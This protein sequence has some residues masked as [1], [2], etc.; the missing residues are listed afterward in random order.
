MISFS[1]VVHLMR[2]LE[3]VVIKST[4]YLRVFSTKE[5]TPSTAVN[6]RVPSL[7]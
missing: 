7:I 6:T 4:V 2:Q 5:I 1:V 3:L